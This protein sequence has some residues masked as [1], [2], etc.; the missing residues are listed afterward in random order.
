MIFNTHNRQCLKKNTTVSSHALKQFYHWTLDK[1]IFACILYAHNSDHVFLIS[2][3]LS[4][5]SVE[6]EET[7]HM[8]F[9]PDCF[10]VFLLYPLKTNFQKFSDRKFKLTFFAKVTML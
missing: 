1:N 3:Q 6:S 8:H 4:K 5:M 2:F 10:R 7:F 9:A